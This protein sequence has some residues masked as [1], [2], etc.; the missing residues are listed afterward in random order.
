MSATNRG[1]TRHD[2]DFYA[3]PPE[4]T[5]A[6]LRWLDRQQ[7]RVDSALDPAAGE[8]ALL[9]ELRPSVRATAYEIRNGCQARLAGLPTT[10]DGARVCM[11]DALTW[12]GA[13]RGEGVHDLVICNPPFSL[14]REFVD[15]YRYVGLTSAF[16]LRLNFL[17]S[18]KR[19]PWW[20]ANPPAHVLVLPVR[21][22]FTA[23]GKTDAVEYAWVVYRGRTAR[24]STKVDWLH[25]Y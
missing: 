11:V 24:G 9:A 1:A 17:G 5:Q 12:P 21:P 8:G 3:T 15:A 22:S 4:T 2:H 18:Q 23:D 7:I 14:A 19:A 13:D 20:L 10:D 25:L 6:L 16:L